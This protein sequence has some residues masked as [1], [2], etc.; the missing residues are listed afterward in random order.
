MIYVHG[1]IKNE[2][3]FDAMLKNTTFSPGLLMIQLKL[4]VLADVYV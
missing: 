1:E 3:I 4:F 2:V